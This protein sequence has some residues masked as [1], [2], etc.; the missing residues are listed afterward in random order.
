MVSADLFSP[1][2]S[3]PPLSPRSQVVLVA[4]NSSERAEQLGAICVQEGGLV[5]YARNTAELLSP[6]DDVSPD[7]IILDTLFRGVSGLELCGELRA[8]SALRHTPVML[9]SNDEHPGAPEVAAGLLSGA[10]DFCSMCVA[11]RDELRARVRVQLRNKLYRDA[12]GRLRSERNRLRCRISKDSLTGALG[13]SALDQVVEEALNRGER[14]AVLFLD[15][16]H[17]KKVNDGH[18]HQVGDQ[19]LRKVAEVLHSGCRA[20]DACG[21]YGG[22]EFV[23]VLPGVDAETATAVADRHRGAIAKLDFERIGGPPKVTVSV[24]VGAF[25]P[26]APDAGAEALLRRAD[27]AL[28][29]AKASGRNR[30]VLAVAAPPSEG[31]ARSRVLRAVNGGD[32]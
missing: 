13:R 32:L 28:Y 14:F 23:M 20:G 17:F 5:R 24:G 15:I 21:R 4:A 19:V 8:G 3:D 25:D 2:L 9:V 26:G 27:G 7:L 30:V 16:D 12:L 6:A 31:G 29:Q 18:G 11:R 22:E 1:E 10:D